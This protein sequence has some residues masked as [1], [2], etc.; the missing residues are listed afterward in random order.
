MKRVLYLILFLSASLSAQTNQHGIIF[1]TT[2]FNFH[3]V[4]NWISRIDS[5]EITNTTT[6][7][8]FFLKQHY[9]REFEIKFPADGIAPGEK[10]FIEIIYNP[11][12][13][14]KFKVSIP[15][16][17][18][19]ATDPVMI[20]YVGEVLSFDPF[21]NAACPSFTNPNYKRPEFDLEILVIDSLSGKALGAST[22]E[23]AKGEL[24]ITYKTDSKGQ[25][26]FKSNIGMFHFYAEHEGYKSKEVQDY[27]N[28]DKRKIT[29]TLVPVSLQ[30]QDVVVV[31]VE[32]V[33]DKLPET[34]AA[35]PAVFS[36]TNYKENNIVFLIDVSK[37]MD[38][39]DRLPLLKSSMIELTRLMRKE[40]KITILTY[41]DHV[42]VHLE[43]TS[44]AEPEKIIAV[45]ES[46]KAGGSTAGDEA[47]RQAYASVQK[48]FIKGGVNQIIIATDGGFDGLGKT[49]DE[50]MNLIRKKSKKN[51]RFSAL[52]FGQNK[53]GKK[54]IVRLAEVGQGFYL[55]IQNEEEA[56][57]KLKE[58]IKSQ[59]LRSK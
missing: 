5:I 39:F 29:I 51:I 2:S 32:I 15:V 14:G 13:T 50:M 52:T 47:I 8:V 48:S 17:H 12:N 37:S 43:T 31:V 16:F 21:A 3:K 28:P 44:G 53:L 45:I 40:D 9:P 25:I 23:M 30:K 38:G 27:F 36:L 56:K 4:E 11:I 33:P 58:A 10:K 1:S 26:K 24:Y 49:E 59:G 41:S 6:K 57:E 7:K 20:S 34:V 54:F 22:V 35:D 18:T 19:A 46:L 55:F 42:K